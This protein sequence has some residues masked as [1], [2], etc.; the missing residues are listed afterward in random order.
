MA[1]GTVQVWG[2]M[3]GS[4]GL[5]SW[6]YGVGKMVPWGW[7]DGFNRTYGTYKTY[8]RNKTYRT[9]RTGVDGWE[10]WVRGN[11]DV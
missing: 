3:D 11:V 4:V 9:N 1:D 8:R 6:D 2:W 10:C 5:E 7:K